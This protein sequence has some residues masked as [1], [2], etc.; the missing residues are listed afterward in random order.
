MMIVSKKGRIEEPRGLLLSSNKNTKYVHRSTCVDAYYLRCE[1]NKTTT[2]IVR[3]VRVLHL[4]YVCS[5]L[6][7]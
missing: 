7:E 5:V 4:Q 1:S 2:P 3:S 6:I